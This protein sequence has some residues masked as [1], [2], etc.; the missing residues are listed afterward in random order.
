MAEIKNTFQGSKMNQDLDD[1]LIPNGTYRSATNIQVGNSESDDVG[2]LQTVLGN[3]ELTEFGIPSTVVGLEVVGHAIDASKDVIVVFLTNSSTDQRLSIVDKTGSITLP[4]NTTVNNVTKSTGN[5]YV[6]MYS[7]G[8]TGILVEGSFL[9]FSKLF[10]VVANIVEDL[11][12]FTDNFNQPR[13]INIKSAQSSSSYYTNEDQISVAKY[14]PYQ[15]ISFLDTSSGIKKLGLVNKQDEYLPPSLVAFGS[16]Y[17]AGSGD[18]LVILKNV[19]D[20]SLVDLI[21]HMQTVNSLNNHNISLTSQ[22]VINGAQK[23]IKISNLSKEGSNECYVRRIDIKANGDCEIKIENKDGSDIVNDAAT[24]LSSWDTMDQLGFS[25]PNPDYDTS[26]AYSGASKYMEDKFLKFSYRFKFDDDEYS[27]MAPFT[28]A[29]FI[30]KQKGYFVGQDAKRAGQKGIVPFMENEVTNVTLNIPMPIVTSALGNVELRDKFKVKEVQIL[31]KASDDQNI[32]VVTDLEL[33]SI[34]GGISTATVTN[35]GSNSSITPFS[36]GIYTVGATGGSGSGML[37]KVR[38]SSTSTG[39]TLNYPDYG[40]LDSNFIQV[41]SPGVGYTVGDVLTLDLDFHDP[42]AVDNGASKATITVAS[43]TNYIEYNYNSQQP[44]KVLPSKEITRVSDIVPIKALAQAVVGNR[45]VYGNFLQKYGNLDKLDYDIEISDKKVLSNNDQQIKEHPNHTVKQGRTYQVGVVLRDRYGRTSNVIINDDTSDKSS[46]I[47]VPYTAGGSD[48]LEFFGRSLKIKWNREIPKEASGQWPGL[49]HEKDNPLGWHSYQIVV[50]QKQQDY[51]NVYVPGSMSG[52]IVFKGLG[53]NTDNLDFE[54]DGGN[55][56]IVLYGDNINKVPRELKEVG[57]Q[58]TQFGSTTDL[59]CVVGEPLIATGHTG[60][61]IQTSAQVIRTSQQLLDPKRIKVEEFKKFRDLGDWTMYKGV[62][63]KHLDG[64]GSNG[65]QFTSNTYIYPGSAGKADPLYLDGN[66]N[67]YVLKLAT[68]SRLGYLGSEQKTNWEFSKRLH[69]FETSPVES[70][71]EIFYETSTS[72]LISELNNSIRTA[73]PTGVLSDISPIVF[74]LQEGDA[75]STTCTNTFEVMSGS[76]K[77]NNPLSVIKIKKVFNGNGTNVTSDWSIVQATAGSSGTSP[78]FQ[79]K[80][81]KKYVFT[82]GSYDGDCLFT[83][84]LTATC[85][86]SEGTVISRDFV[87]NNFRVT[88]MDP[89]IYNL[90]VKESTFLNA[91]FNSG[92]TSNKLQWTHWLSGHPSKTMYE[93]AQ[94]NGSSSSASYYGASNPIIVNQTNTTNN[95]YGN[96][97]DCVYIEQK[98]LNQNQGDLGDSLRYANAEFVTNGFEPLTTFNDTTAI[99]VNNRLDVKQRLLGVNVEIVQAF[100]YH[101]QFEK[102][103]SPKYYIQGGGADNAMSSWSVYKSS[104]LHT[105]GPFQFKFNYNGTIQNRDFQF[106]NAGGGYK[107]AFIY[108]IVVVAKDAQ[109]SSGGGYGAGTRESSR[110]VF[111]FIIFK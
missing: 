79:I 28:Q 85:P 16:V 37:V 82:E 49:Y 2:T 111:H 27:L 25:W 64:T 70:S 91:E 55:S 52:S 45:V 12:F 1:R 87:F 95:D 44:I 7:P 84:T 75:I 61:S 103:S 67:P 62:N 63:L 76:A 65:G 34:V 92:G 38:R 108:E 68:N 51:Y 17:T 5:N 31:S 78:T 56:H 24:V 41:V 20:D 105:D 93:M 57:S 96:T 29:A 97:T 33:E 59:F 104:S 58:D 19:T 101:G 26:F 11:M 13:K 88:N 53:A 81:N 8:F 47:Y 74:A 66:K 39:N 72:G 54:D 48:P 71:I 89:I 109:S 94:A 100:R 9:N 30:P 40:P 77:I 73:E 10:R 98:R 22:S 80:N 3:F 42:V 69:V 102:D 86:D 46:T 90:T 83:F 107:A 21:A 4:D 50:K 106:S 18:D 110:K 15:P 36:P 32:K 99:G 60:N 23:R 14:Y 43:L 6:C 35:T